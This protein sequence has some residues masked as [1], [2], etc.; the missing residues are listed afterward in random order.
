M[1]KEA[2]FPALIERELKSRGRGNLTVINAGISGST[3][4]SGPGRLKWH[5]KGTA[6]PDILVL[7]LGANDGLRGIDL[8][9][10]RKNLEDVITAAKSVGSK[11]L[12][13]GMKIPPNYG[14]KY[15]DD[16]ES[17]FKEI[18]AKHEIGLIPFLLE[19]V[20]G[21]PKLNLPDGIHPNEEGMKIVAKTVLKYLEPML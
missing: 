13:A 15:A 8:T 9:A 17:M 5:L 7:A 16:F 20:G 3:T 11:I 1:P 4:A 12:L 19:G 21:E 2:A 18:A 14:K 10:S 6:R